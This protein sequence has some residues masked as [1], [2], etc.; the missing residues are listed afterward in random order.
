MKSILIFTL[1]FILLI[2]ILI[3][4]VNATEHSDPI[5]NWK[6]FEHGQEQEYKPPPVREY[7]YH[8]EFEPTAKQWL[9]RNFPN[10]IIYKVYPENSFDYY[11]TEGGGHYFDSDAPRIEYP[12]W[13]LTVHYWAGHLRINADE[14]HNAFDFMWDYLQPNPHI[15]SNIPE[16][17]KYIE[18]SVMALT[19]NEKVVRHNNY[20]IL[21]QLSS[22]KQNQVQYVIKNTNNLIVESDEVYLDDSNNFEIKFK[23]SDQWENGWH[24][25]IVYHTTSDGFESVQTSFRLFD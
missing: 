19:T 16:L 4:N 8:V 11:P 3:S 23:P 18:K 9:D 21:G 6:E 5:S 10:P 7:R 14:A 22:S 17:E 13:I 12:L 20:S 2:P 25:V 24:Y 15:E 1:V